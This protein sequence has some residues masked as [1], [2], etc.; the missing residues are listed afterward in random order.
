MSSL[1]EAA[2][3]D[4]PALL[5]ASLWARARGA[6]QS[7]LGL[8]YALLDQ[9][10]YSV[11]NLA[12]MALLARHAT[13][14]EF[15][16]YILTQRALDVLIQLC[17]VLLWGPYTFNIAAMEPAR[18]RSYRGSVLLH[19]LLACAAGAALLWCAARWASTPAR[20]LYYGVF[21]P[22]VLSSIGILFREYTRRIYFAALR[23]REAFWTD[24]AT[25]LLQIAGVVLL[26]KR[27]HLHVPETLWALA[28]GAWIVNAWW[29]LREWRSVSVSL[30]TALVDWRTNQRL[31]RWLLGSN[32]VFVASSQCNPWVIGAL[33]GPASVG[34]Y[35]VCEAVVNVPR[36]ALVSLQ[37]VLAPTLARAFAEGGKPRLRKLVAHTDRLLLVGSALFA[38]L[39]CAAGPWA[40]SLIGK[41]VPHDARAILVLLALN[42]VAYAATMAQGYGLTAIG[43]AS[44]TFYANLA[45]ISAQIVLVVFL[46]RRLQVPGAAAAML[47]GSLVVIAVR[48]VF[49]SREMQ[50]PA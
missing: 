48:Q 31:G 8:S 16:I 19:Q 15:G 12:V 1:P 40:A 20:G 35:A 5:P 21:A 32:M 38:A 41:T 36:V 17:N 34:V 45:G 24:V 30:R 3:G 18:Q 14:R 7:R 10:A 46:V 37:N 22:L 44:P 25:T 23:L 33:L 26:W 49:Y 2:I 47:V 9:V 13:A 39:I 50:V 29:V 28:I 4:E 27:G 11:G 6:V 43:K 42:F